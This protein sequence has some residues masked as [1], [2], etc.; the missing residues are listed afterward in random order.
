MSD[1]IYFCAIPYVTTEDP[2]VIINDFT[3]WPNTPANWIK[4]TGRDWS[5]HMEQYQDRQ[6][7]PVG[8]HGSVLTHKDVTK[9]L[10]HDDFYDVVTCLSTAAWLLT[11]KVQVADSWLLETWD[12]SN[13]YKPKEDVY[14]RSGKFQQ[15][16]NSAD[17]DKLIPNPYTRPIKFNPIGDSGSNN[18]AVLQ[19]VAGEL[20]KKR[21]DSAVTAMHRFHRA[22]QATP[23]YTSIGDD[24]EGLWSGF[25]S[26]FKAPKNT[27][28]NQLRAPLAAKA[29]FML[30]SVSAALGAPRC[31]LLDRFSKD[32]RSQERWEWVFDRI[33]DE[34]A[35]EAAALE[36]EF[37]NQVRNW[38]EKIYEL[39]SMHT[40]GYPHT[41]V[42]IRLADHLPSLFHIG[43]MLAYSIFSFRAYLR[44]P[45]NEFL[46]HKTLQFLN[47]TFC[48]YPKAD[49]IIA[50]IK[51]RKNNALLSEKI[52]DDVANA[53][54]DIAYTERTIGEYENANKLFD[55][56]QTI[57]L[58]LSDFA[59]KLPSMGFDTNNSY[60]QALLKLPD[61]IKHAVQEA[62]KA[63]HA[64]GAST[65]P[66]YEK[67]EQLAIHHATLKF[68]EEENLHKPH[69][70]HDNNPS[71]LEKL[72]IG[73]T[74]SVWTFV[75]LYVKLREMLPQE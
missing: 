1:R 23:Y 14:E 21:E 39:R 51:Q 36:P 45:G 68:L 5:A 62:K 71:T 30:R 65:Q 17:Y 6:G 58:T 37:W 22:R 53:I 4:H 67:K 61:I 33:K 48:D 31:C 49:T 3:L 19:Y 75:A 27:R 52:P 7:N 47:G 55:V 10:S 40:H 15:N 32:K 74:V 28:Q 29:L 46:L 73:Q 59:K 66:G 69:R 44:S 20:L 9:A 11:L 12:L 72:K 70:Y 64:R 13:N 38:A 25:E 16:W 60:C 8:Q 57:N 43:V 35:P 34:L 41:V 26:L 63:K 24:L 50:F 2:G 42:D 56:L 18:H 54:K